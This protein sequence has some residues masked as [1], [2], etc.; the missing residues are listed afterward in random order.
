MSPFRPYVPP[1]AR[2]RTA[3]QDA[4]VPH[5]VP[6]LRGALFVADIAGF[7]ALTE[8]KARDG[9]AGIE[10]MQAILN[11]CFEPIVAVIEEG[12][13][14]VYKFAGDATIACW[15]ATDGDGRAAVLAAASTALRLRALVPELEA[16]A[17]APLSL[18]IGIGAGDLYTAILGGVQGRWE[19][20]L[21]GAALAQV[22][23]TETVAPGQVVL[24]GEA[25]EM[26]RADCNGTAQPGGAFVIDGVTPPL[27]TDGGAAEAE[28]AEAMLVPFVPRHV[29]ERIHAS[30]RG[31][32]AELRF[33]TVLFAT[34]RAPDEIESLQAAVGRMQRSVYEFGGSVVQCLVDDK[35]RLAVVAAWGIAGSSYSNDAER[36]VRAARSLHLALEAAAQTP[37]IG[38]ASGRLFAG[39][40]GAPSRCEFALIGAAVNLAARLAEAAAGKVWCD[41]ATARAVAAIAFEAQA[42]VELKGIGSV[43]VF[44]PRGGRLRAGAEAG[45]PVGRDA[46]LRLLAETLQRVKAKPQRSRVV[47]I[48][49]EP[50]IG[51]SHLA[52]A[53]AQEVRRAGLVLARGGCEPLDGAS[54]WRPLR[55]AF[56]TLLGLEATGAEPERRRRVLALIGADPAGRERAPLLGPVLDLAIEETATTHEMSGRGRLDATTELLLQL[57]AATDEASCRVVLLEDVHWLDS[58]SWTVL[59][60]AAQHSRGL[61]LV[62]VARPLAEWPIAPHASA[63]LEAAG[64]VRLHV[65]ALAEGALRQVIEAQLGVAAVPDGLVRVVGDR[66]QGVPLFVRQVLG[67]LVDAGIVRVES[68]QARCDDKALAAFAVPDSI[69]G[70]VISRIDRLSP[71]QQMTLKKASVVGRSFTLEALASADAGDVSAGDL[72]DD[73]EAIV[74]R[75]LVHRQES[76]D[77]FAFSHALVRDAVYG[78]LTYERRRELHA[79]LAAWYERRSGDDPA[80]FARI[81]NHHA[82]A[83]DPVRAPRALEKAAQRALRSGANREAQALFRRLL[84]IAESGFGEGD[85]TRLAASRDDLARWQQGLGFASYDVGDLADSCRALEAAAALLDAALPTERA[86]QVRLTLEIVRALLRG[87]L[88]RPKT[89]PVASPRDRQL[90]RVLFALSRIYHLSQRRNHTLFAMMSRFN[91]IGRCEPVPEQMSAIAGVMYLVMMFGRHRLAHRLAERIALIHRRLQQPLEYAGASYIAA[92]AYLIQAHW[93]DCERSA[94]EAEQ[95]FARLGERQLRL[96]VVAVLANAA[97]LRGN[98]QRSWTLSTSL[99]ALAEDS[100]D[101]LNKCWAAGGLAT[102]AMRQGRIEVAREWAETAVAIARTIGESVSYLSNRGLLAMIAIETGDLEAARSLVDEGVALLAE[103]P[104]FA[105][106]HHVLYGLDTFSEAIL[107]LWEREAPAPGSAAWKRHASRAALGI[108]RMKGYAM[109]FSIGAPAAANRQALGHWLHGRRARAI[110]AWNKAIGEAERMRIPYESG[111][112]HLELA[113]HLPLGAAA[114]RRHAEAGAAIFERIGAAAGLSRCQAAGPLETAGPVARPAT[115]PVS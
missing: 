9:Q 96:S 11:R 39:L 114:R 75:G 26:I 47:L 63:L 81:A 66:T 21:G 20:V 94:G 3:A 16:A 78:L 110:A 101:Q 105:T 103:L 8:R 86:V 58:P 4:L 43:P 107:V 102:V 90:A 68:G 14:E 23:Q 17:N 19:A 41:E 40:R 42:P 93:E 83:H 61:L 36:S 70:A 25:F 50:G 35:G 84:Q 60:Q 30:P 33:A 37:S 74:R 67:A 76:G 55:T 2:R 82:E 79:A 80:L 71:R 91:Q 112:A 113:R 53:F 48:E 59:E 29:V 92:L 15:F 1:F 99:L 6:G 24:S 44:E 18:R 10:E 104:R 108:S 7:T 100:G 32:L 115:S 65:H 89:L 97:E 28:P 62:L 13:G 77:A 46:E 73:I 87:L 45:A 85:P 106:A 31:W 38:V 12:G 95:I 49:G 72:R 51:K 22:A 98:L 111:K 54:A 27:P 88:P 52:E 57:V 64:T 34:V 56:H 5:L 69:Q 109:S